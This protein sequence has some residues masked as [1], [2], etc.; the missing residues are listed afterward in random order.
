MGVS[1]VPAVFLRAAALLGVIVSAHWCSGSGQTGYLTKGWL[2]CLVHCTVRP[3][4]DVLLKIVKFAVVCGAYPYAQAY[5]WRHRP[6]GHGFCGDSTVC[7]VCAESSLVGF[8]D[9]FGMLCLV[10]LFIHEAD[11]AHSMTLRWICAVDLL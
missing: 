6:P 8:V 9:G 4:T 1:E 7:F 3:A 2:S 11:P 5:C 10:A